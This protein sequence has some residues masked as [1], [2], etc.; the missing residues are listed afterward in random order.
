MTTP[1]STSQ[2]ALTEFLGS[3]T[4]SFG[5]WMQLMALV[6]TTGSFGNRVAGLDRMVDVVQ[7]DGDELADVGHRAAEARRAAHQW[8]LVGLELAQLGQRG[9]A[10][11][12]AVEVLDDRAEV[13]QPALGID[14]AGLFLA[15]V[16]IANEFHVCV[17]LA[18]TVDRIAAPMS[19]GARPCLIRQPRLPQ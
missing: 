19:A 2:S 10:E 13:A 11:R 6:N 15:G 18:L 16:A 14:Q 3:M 1:S 12:G 4:G 8:Q 9:I 5:P 7:A 17:F